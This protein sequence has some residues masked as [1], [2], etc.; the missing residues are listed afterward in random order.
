MHQLTDRRLPS[1][2]PETAIGLLL[3]ILGVSLAWGDA[4]I[5]RGPYL[6]DVRADGVVVRWDTA[7]PSVGAVRLM[8]RGGQPQEVRETQATKRHQV[9][10]Q[11]LT[12]GIRYL[13][14]VVNG[15]TDGPSGSFRTTVPPGRGFSFVAYGDSRSR[16]AEHG[17]VADA[18]LAADPAFVLHTGDM[19]AD[20]RNLEDWR[21]FF[22]GARNLLPHA[23]IFPSLGN[24]ERNA[25]LYFDFFTLP[26]NERYYS[27]DYGD[28]HFVALDSDPPY[29]SSR[30]QL[31]WLARDLEAHQ[32]AALTFVFFHHPPY[33]VGSHGSS[34]AVQENFCPLFEKY[35]VDVAFAGHDHDYQRNEVGGI[36]YVVTGGG[37]A[38]LYD[39]KTTATWNKV[40][41]KTLHY[42]LVTV[43]DADVREAQGKAA[44][45]EA[46]TP[47]GRSFDRVELGS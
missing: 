4:D 19:A 39:Q 24:H 7:T 26:G 15:P 16:L 27:F 32:G 47:D 40:T 11:G 2:L 44:L 5:V 14:Q 35:G 8:P 22:E 31:D 1:S 34:R 36:V 42:V 20:G 37:G 3:I 30:E 10:L 17:Q 12:A 18:I 28:C 46:F 29:V 6:N 43:Y 21:V 9:R 41:R 23:P 38:P 13:Y 25:P 45:M 33:S